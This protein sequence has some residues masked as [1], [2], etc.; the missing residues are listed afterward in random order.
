MHGKRGGACMSGRR[1]CL[2][3]GACVQEK[4]PLNRAVFILLECI[5]VFKNYQ[6]L[7]SIDGQNGSSPTLSVIQPVIIDTM[8]NNNGPSFWSFAEK[9]FVKQRMMLCVFEILLK[10]GRFEG[11]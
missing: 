9:T 10:I 11:G 7:L 2:A 1:A 8:L 5:L 3:S 6:L 4:R